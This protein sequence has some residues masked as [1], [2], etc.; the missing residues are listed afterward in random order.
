MDQL[1]HFREGEDF[2]DVSKAILFDADILVELRRRAEKLEEETMSTK[3][4]HR[5]NFI[6]LRRMTRDIKFMRFE[7]T[8][9]EEEIKQ[10]MMRRF[11]I[12]INL[13]ELE[14]EVLRRYVFE[15]ETTAEQ[16]M[17]ALEKELSER[18]VS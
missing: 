13:D 2:R 10:A 14:E 8:R 3:R 17:R 6:H 9:L 5:I 12:I 1:Q 4:W 16:E 7:I 18:Q 15:L 11:G